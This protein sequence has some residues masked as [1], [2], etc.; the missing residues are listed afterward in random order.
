MIIIAT[1]IYGPISQPCL[2][3]TVP[4]G[5]KWLPTPDTRDWTIP[6]PVAREISVLIGQAEFPR[7]S[8]W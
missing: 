2:Q 8:L 7:Q 5:N 1:D 6:I 4:Q 3:V